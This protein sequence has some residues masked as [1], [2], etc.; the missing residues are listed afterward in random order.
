MTVSGYHYVNETSVVLLGPGE[1]RLSILGG[2]VVV[3]GLVGQ[4][5]DTVA[6]VCPGLTEDSHASCSIL[7]LSDIDVGSLE[8]R[9]TEL[10]IITK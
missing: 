4:A 10:G 9:A 8:Q 6:L 5:P 3:S 1:M 2:T 7:N